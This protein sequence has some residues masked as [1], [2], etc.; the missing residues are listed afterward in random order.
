MVRF[1]VTIC[2]KVNINK[3]FLAHPMTAAFQY[4]MGL[5]INSYVIRDAPCELLRHSQT[6][7]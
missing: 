7:V 4:Y 1:K 2:I 6:L 3:C 5:V